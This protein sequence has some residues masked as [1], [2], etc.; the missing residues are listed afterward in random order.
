MV[1]MST[2]LPSTSP[3][4][5][6]GNKDYCGEYD[7]CGIDDFCV[8]CTT[9]NGLRMPQEIT[10]EANIDFAGDL[11]VSIG[12]LGPQLEELKLGSGTITA[13]QS[14]VLWKTTLVSPARI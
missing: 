6:L 14:C 12:D 1:N 10:K 5:D 3:W 9:V 11:P 13:R 4:N 8:V 7:F 2:T